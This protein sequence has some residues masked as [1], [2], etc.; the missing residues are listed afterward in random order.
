MY[1]F[2]ALTAQAENNRTML[3]LI[4]RIFLVFAI[5]ALVMAVSGIYGVMA[6]HI[7]QRT[8]E[9][10]IRRA[11][12]AP[13]A[14]I[15]ALFSRQSALQLSVGFMLGIPLA[16]F[17]SQ[18]FI[19]TI[20]AENRLHLLAYVLVPLI[21]TIAVFIATLIPLQRILHIEPAL[22]LRYE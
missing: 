7:E 1:R 11:L 9:L 15:L 17:M 10:G 5:C 6:N 18:G 8:Q 12:G 19:N 13:D 3:D 20:G 14:R 21:I 16:Y 22:A 4:E 2:A